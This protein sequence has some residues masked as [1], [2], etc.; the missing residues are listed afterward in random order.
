MYVGGTQGLF[1]REGQQGSVTEQPQA[2]SYRFGVGNFLLRVSS[3]G[4]AHWRIV[5]K[6][7]QLMTVL[8]WFVGT[9]GQLYT[10]SPLVEGGAKIVRYNPATDTW[11]DVTPISA[12]WT[13]IA[14]TPGN[15]NNGAVLWA[16]SSGN[17]QPALY[18]Y[19]V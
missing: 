13:L 8:N 7:S 10:R 14:V 1:P 18:R 6:A 2:S 12:S 4:G 3:D 5:T 11:S 17:E 9:D 16:V 19:V 15:A